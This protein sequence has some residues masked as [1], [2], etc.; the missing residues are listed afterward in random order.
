M[1]PDTLLTERQEITLLTQG[2]SGVGVSGFYFLPPL[3][4]AQAS[5]G[6]F[7]S[8]FEPEVVIC[9]L[10]GSA[11]AET[12]VT[13][14]TTGTG[15]A[16]VRV[17]E[18]DEHYIVNWKTG[19]FDL[20]SGQVYRITVLVEDH[21]IGSVDVRLVNS[22]QRPSR[23]AEAIIDVVN[24][25][26]LPIKFRIESEGNEDGAFVTTWDTNL[27]TGTT[28]TLALAGTVNA[29]ID[30]GDGSAIQQ[31]TTPGP[32]VHDY[33]IDGIY[34]VSV[35]GT[36]TA[37]NSFSNG[38]ALSERAK[39]VR[40]DAWGDVGFTSMQFAFHVAVNLVSV[41]GTSEGL[42]NVTNMSGMFQDA[43]SFN[44]AI[45]SWDT[46]NVTHMNL[47]FLGAMAFNQ[48][49]GSWDTG[50]VTDMSG[51]FHLAASFNQP[52]G[53]WNTGNVTSMGGMF[54][55]ATAFNQPIGSWDTGNVTDMSYMFGGATVFNQD[56]SG[57]C[58]SQIPSEPSFFDMDATGWVL[59]DSRP[60]WG[61][62]PTPT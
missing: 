22:G 53:S 29:W 47:M 6:T 5:E 34:T 33:G 43:T 25:S 21:E 49:I 13:F 37:Y 16:S 59:P 52:I 41:P 31:V 8:S 61:T 26:T 4:R 44:S 15:P 2:A 1:S 40:V 50:N 7:D 30:W 28:V 23:R 19:D 17:D 38:G 42:E 10:S 45:G 27:G 3:A 39:L 9:R 12:V 11:C 55:L 60:V 36:V 14:T 35:T 57:W 32:H 48:P 56:L 18:E 20:A 62:C 51:M 54:H 46:G 58:V 24:G